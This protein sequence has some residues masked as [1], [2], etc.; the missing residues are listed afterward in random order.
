MNKNTFYVVTFVD[1]HGVSHVGR[2]FGK[3]A[4][5]RKWAKFVSGFGKEVRIMLGGPGGIEVR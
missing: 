3:I 5:A 2:S 1:S 4:A